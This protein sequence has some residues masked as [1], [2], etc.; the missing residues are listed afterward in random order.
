MEEIATELSARGILNIID[1]CYDPYQ[2]IGYKI[3]TIMA[4]YGCDSSK[5]LDRQ[6]GDSIDDPDIREDNVYKLRIN[7]LDLTLEQ[8]R[9]D[10][11]YENFASIRI[12]DTQNIVYDREQH[13]WVDGAW[14]EVI[15]KLFKNSINIYETVDE[16][17]F[18]FNEGITFNHSNRLTSKIIEMFD[19]LNN[20]KVAERFCK[21]LNGEAIV[22]DDRL[23]ITKDIITNNEEKI[24]TNYRI[25]DMNLKCEEVYSVRH[26]VETG[27]DTYTCNL[28]DNFRPGEWQEYILNYY[29]NMVKENNKANQ[30]RKSK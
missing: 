3:Q 8:W 2:K 26:I 7:G 9:E 13:I 20:C 6:Y 28:I 24:E 11:K 27:K 21:S 15:E 4:A 22:L 1:K 5:C 30:K 23:I 16:Y 18:D 17:E 14:E 29:D 12:A 25:L 10:F 19:H